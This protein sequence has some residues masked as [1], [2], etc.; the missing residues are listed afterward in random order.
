MLDYNK[1]LDRPFNLE[2]PIEAGR[3]KLSVSFMI[4]PQNSHKS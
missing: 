2:V 4:S 1:T 3:L